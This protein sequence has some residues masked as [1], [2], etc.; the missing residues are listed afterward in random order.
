MLSWTGERMIPEE[1]PPGTLYGHIYR[2]KFAREHL[3]PSG[4]VVDLASGEGYGTA[5]LREQSRRVIGFDIDPDSVVHAI[6]K[7]GG[8]YRV[9]SGDAVPLDTGSVDGFVSFETLEH[10]TD[11]SLLLDEAQRVLRPGGVLVCSTPNAAIYDTDNQFHLKEL[12]LEEFSSALS[13]RFRTVRLFGQHNRETTG[14]WPGKWRLRHTWCPTL[15]LARDAP[16]AI[17]AKDW[18]LGSW[19]NP[20]TVHADIRPTDEILLAVATR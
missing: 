19:I 18:P 14:R 16:R 12:T 7:Y 15:N 3:P 8:E 5:A 2:Y 9:A 10:L 20:Y 1:S 17:R 13:A 4:V 6:Q 11:P